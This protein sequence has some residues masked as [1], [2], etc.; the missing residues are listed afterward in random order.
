MYSNVFSYELSSARNSAT[1][2]TKSGYYRVARQR[3][4]FNTTARPGQ[5]QT[6][7]CRALV[8]FNSIYLVRHGSSTTFGTGLT[9]GRAF[10]RNFTVCSQVSQYAREYLDLLEQ[11]Q[12]NVLG[13]HVFLYVLVELAVAQKLGKARSP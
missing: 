8:E 5:F 6:S 7:H 1:F 4:P 2:E 9:H 10:F 13:T 11:G 12:H 3:L